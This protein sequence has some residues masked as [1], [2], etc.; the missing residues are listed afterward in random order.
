MTAT[1]DRFPGLAARLSPLRPWWPPLAVA[2]LLAA[3]GAA[4]VL[5]SPS[6]T[7]V[8]LTTPSGDTAS[9]GGPPPS[10]MPP[11][12]PPTDPGAA[13]GGALPAWVM[14]VALVVCLVAAAAVVLPLLYILLRAAVSVRRGALPV[15]HTPTAPPAPRREEVLAAVDAGLADLSDADR[16]PR[17]A[18]IACWVRLEQAAA[19]AGTPRRPG[20][21]STDLVLRV[22]DAHRVDRRVLDQFAA[23]YREARYATHPVG[24]R[25][26]GQAQS[27]LR[28]LR[29]ELAAG[30]PAGVAT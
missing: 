26:R 17:R 3:A 20:D 18:V 19:S 12:P 13:S 22:L 16:D 10:E 28:Q 15:D 14:S 5:S 1:R 8:P 30:A 25:E 21:T 27:A 9:F 4:A 24:E 11:A 7:E 2:G 23:L 6:V 29:G